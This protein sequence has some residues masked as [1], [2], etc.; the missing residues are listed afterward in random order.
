MKIELYI[1]GGLG[2]QLYQYAA[3]RCVQELYGYDE[4]H[5]IGDVFKKFKLRNLEICNYQLHPSVVWNG[6]ISSLENLIRAAYHVF[7]KIYHVTFKKHARQKVFRIGGQQFVCST[8]PF[9]RPRLDAGKNVFMYGYFASADNALAMKHRLMEELILKGERTQTYRNYE[10][11]IDKNAI[12]VSVRC[13]DDYVNNGWPVCTGSF[14]QSGIDRII[15]KKGNGKVFVFADNLERVRK[16]KW[17]SDDVI[18]VEGLSVCES[19]ELMRHFENYV[20]SNSSFSWWGAFLSYAQLPLIYSSNVTFSEKNS[21]DNKNIRYQGVNYLNYL[22]GET[23]R[24]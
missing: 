19:F 14:Y 1:L 21:E 11:K 15:E 7:Q 18:Y 20:C 22:T 24:V 6:R 10:K 5:I 3:A 8:T 13:D 17:F 16:N 23:E 12:A 9:Q 4:L 2:N